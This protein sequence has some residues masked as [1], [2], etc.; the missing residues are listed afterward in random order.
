M[1]RIA[2]LWL[3]VMAAAVISWLVAGC[4]GGAPTPLQADTGVASAQTQGQPSR[5]IVVFQGDFVNEPAQEALVRQFGEPLK[6]LPLV[7]GMVVLLPPTAKAP[8]AQQAQVL[9]IDVDAE[10]HALP[11]PPGTPGKGPDN[12]DEEP[13]PPQ[14]LPWGVNRID[15]EHAWPDYTGT[16]VKVAVVDTGIDKDHPDLAVAGGVN[17]GRGPAKKWDD[18]NGHGTHVAGTI[19]ALDNEI[20]VVGVAPEASLWAVKVLDRNGEGYVSDVIEGIEWCIANGMQVVNMSLGT[21]SDIQSLHDACDAA[22]AAGLLL[23]AAAGNDYGNGVDYP[24]AYDT[25]IAV[26]ATDASDAFASFSD[27]GPQVELA[28]PGV[29]VPSTC[30]AA[31]DG[32]IYDGDGEV[33]GYAILS[34][35]SMAAPH[36]AGTAALA[37]GQAEV[38]VTLQETA[39]ALGASEYF[40]HG[41]VD[42]EE[43]ATGSDASGDDLGS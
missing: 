39:D 26:S 20:G 40:G 13:P 23:V 5:Y 41:L 29:D 11:K 36:V 3:F 25:V 2:E 8:L 37:I 24:A 1:R 4:G 43:A 42:A 28:A 31:L 34:G 38:R 17:C 7:N 10:V 16:D 32:S 14:E 35:T 30:T 33:N 6:E 21:N 27:F 19:A 9:R 12:G 18:D 15:A 22:E